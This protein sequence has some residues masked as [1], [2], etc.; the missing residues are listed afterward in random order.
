MAGEQTSEGVPTYQ[1][2]VQLL[3]VGHSKVSPAHTMV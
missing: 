3:V 2:W 1:E